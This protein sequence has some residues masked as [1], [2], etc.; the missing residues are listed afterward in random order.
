M[1]TDVPM[2]AQESLSESAWIQPM[3]L[4]PIELNSNPFLD[5]MALVLNLRNKI[6]VL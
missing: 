1:N 6:F 3:E 5:N 4:V 2:V